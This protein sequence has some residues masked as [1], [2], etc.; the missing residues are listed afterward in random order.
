M[1]LYPLCPLPPTMGSS[2]RS[3]SETIVIPSSGTSHCSNSSVNE[4]IYCRL[5]VVGQVPHNSLN[6]IGFAR[7]HMASLSCFLLILELLL[8]ISFILYYGR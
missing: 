7:I 3:V 4:V 2:A 1:S 8:L 5:G 6:K